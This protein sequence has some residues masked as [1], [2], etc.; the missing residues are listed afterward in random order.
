MLQNERTSAKC[1]IKFNNLSSKSVGH[2]M[3][4]WPLR[5]HL[6]VVC[7][8][9]FRME[10]C[11]LLVGIPTK[12][13]MYISRIINVFWIFV[14]CFFVVRIFSI[15]FLCRLNNNALQQ[16]DYMIL[17][18]DK[19]NYY[20]DYLDTNMYSFCQH[21]YDFSRSIFARVFSD[22]IIVFEWKVCPAALHYNHILKHSL[23]MMTSFW[24]LKIL[25]THWGVSIEFT[26]S[27]H[28]CSF[29]W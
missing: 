2:F 10:N 29:K 19:D 18:V 25:R 7:P 21:F 26:F 23:H 9:V 24:K 15:G 12:H 22:W 3:K 8:H 20:T 27:F 14:F 16:K 28:C 17:C 1:L 11:L 5:M 6:A 13:S 4:T